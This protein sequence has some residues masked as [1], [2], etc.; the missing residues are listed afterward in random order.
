MAGGQA[1]DL[2]SVGQPLTEPE[3][4]A[5]HELKTGALLQASVRMGAACGRGAMPVALDDYGAALGLAFQVVDDILDVTADSA[6]LGKTPG[7]DAAA[8]KPTYVSLLGLQAAQ[9]L[10]DDLRDKAHRALNAS[11]LTRLEPLRALA[12][13]VVQ[14]KH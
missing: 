2:A 6:A 5:M 3:R 7:K 14:R 10:A 9:D 1:L 4:R 13:V 12:D 8:A 11:G